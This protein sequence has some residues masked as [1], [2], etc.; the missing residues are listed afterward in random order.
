MFWNM[1]PEMAT[2]RVCPR[3]RKKEYMAPA[4]GRSS[5]DTGAWHA[6]PWAENSIPVPTPTMRSMA[7]QVAVLV[8][9]LS[10][11]DMPMPAVVKNHPTHFGKVSNRYD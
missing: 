11:I 1:T 7:A 2:P 5:F 4:K 9:S 3:A 8:F 10:T 6:K